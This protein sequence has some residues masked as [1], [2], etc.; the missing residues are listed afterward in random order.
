MNGHPITLAIVLADVANAV[1]LNLRV[2]NSPGHVRVADPLEG[3]WYDP[4]IGGRPAEVSNRGN[5][6]EA[7]PCSRA[8][9]RRER[10]RFLGCSGARAARP[11]RE[12][13]SAELSARAERLRAR[14]NCRCDARPFASQQDRAERTTAPSSARRVPI[15]AKS[16]LSTSAHTS[17]SARKA[18]TRCSVA[19]LRQAATWA[20]RLDRTCDDRPDG[21]GHRPFNRSFM[22]S[23]Q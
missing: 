13:D 18:R 2:T 7:P 16:C 14:L 1:G 8:P 17:M 22:N 3:C 21:A 20:S 9:A 4:F 11:K 6:S 12:S 15:M 10:R 19:G 5:R 23:A